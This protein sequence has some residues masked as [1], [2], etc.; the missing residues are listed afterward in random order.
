MSTVPLRPYRVA[1]SLLCL[2]RAALTSGSILLGGLAGISGGGGG[3]GAARLLEKHM[4]FSPW[5]N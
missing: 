5:V 3:G 1:A 4:L 2:P